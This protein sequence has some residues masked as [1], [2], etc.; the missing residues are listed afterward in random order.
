M[1]MSLVIITTDSPCF[2][3]FTTQTGQRPIVFYLASHPFMCC[4]TYDDDVLKTNKPILMQIGTS[5]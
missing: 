2:Y 3:A 4:Q 1:L 5:D